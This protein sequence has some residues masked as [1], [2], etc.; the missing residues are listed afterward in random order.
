MRTSALMPICCKRA[1]IVQGDLF[2]VLFCT[3]MVKVKGSPAALTR[4][5]SVTVQPASAS[6]STALRS[7]L[8]SRPEPSLTGRR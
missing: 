6:R 1:L 3:E 5:L 2:L 7:I 8:R 4:P